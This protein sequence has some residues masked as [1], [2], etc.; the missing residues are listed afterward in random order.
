MAERLRAGLIGCGFFATNHLNAWRDL[1]EEVELAAVCDL[2]GEKARAAAEAFGVPRAYADAAEMM[3]KE[4]LDFVDVVTTMPSHKP[5]VLLAARHKLPTIVQKPFAPT[6]Q[7]CVDMV[8]ACR[9]AGVPLMVHENFRFQSPMLEVRRVLASGA[10]GE[11]TWGR[12]TWRTNFDVYKGQPYLA[13]EERFILLD[14]GIHVLDLARVLMGEVERLY[15][16][17]QSVRPGIAGEDMATITLKHTSGAVSLVDCTYEAKRDPDPFPETLLE[18]EGRRGSLV[19]SPG[20]DLKVT[21]DGRTTTRSL[22][23]PTLPWT[24]EPWH[25]AQESVLN[26]QR[27]WVECLKAGREPETSGRDNL[28]TYALAEA[29]Y[30]SARTH[31]A[32]T[33]AA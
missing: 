12:I 28:K 29:A 18:L 3:D 5:L 23:T 13:K 32:V 10:I 6:W 20:L 21:S 16:E 26:T 25:V 22:R 8:E 9:A 17:T 33:P 1:G 11:P 14:L 4:R 19:L 7:E 2:D 15:C 30:E 24:A 31:R 27:H